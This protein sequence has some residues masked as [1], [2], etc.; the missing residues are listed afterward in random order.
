MQFNQENKVIIFTMDRTESIAFIK[1]LYS[2]CLRHIKDIE[3]ATKLMEEVIERV[4]GDKC[5]K[6]TVSK[7]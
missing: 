3:E 6:G 2:E 4:T 7:T 1:F 5:N